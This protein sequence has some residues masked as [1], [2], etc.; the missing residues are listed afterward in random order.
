MRAGLLAFLLALAAVATLARADGPAVVPLAEGQ[1]TV[2]LT[3]RLDGEPVR[4]ETTIDVPPG[5]R[6]FPL[7]VF[8]HGS[9][10]RGNDPTLYRRTVVYPDVAAFFVA[11]GY[12]VATPMRRGRGQSDGRYLEGLGPY[13]YTCEHGPMADGIERALADI[14]AAV[15]VLAGQPYVDRSKVLLGGQSRGGILAVAYAGR[16]PDLVRGVVNFV[17]G[18]MGE[19]CAERTEINADTFARAAGRYRKPTLWIYGTDDHFYGIGHSRRNFAAFTRAGGVGEFLEIAPA[20]PGEGHLVIRQST[21]WHSAVAA[22][23]KAIDMP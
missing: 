17:G 10:G 1:Q 11:R 7:L 13:G 9:T 18:W 23:L 15:E 19:D 5:N 3:V 4:L 14:D 20:K 6:T 22:Y 12:V 21:D 8:N 2:L 16:R